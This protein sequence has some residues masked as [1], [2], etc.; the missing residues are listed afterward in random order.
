MKSRPVITLDNLTIPGSGGKPI[1]FDI[2]YKAT[3]K[4]KPIVIFC[5]GFKG[6]KDWGA[7][8][9]MAELF[10]AQNV[11]FIK[12]NFS[13][14]G[15]APG[16]QQDFADLE[17]FGKNTFTKELDDLGRIIDYAVNSDNVTLEEKDPEQ[18][19]LIGH[20][21]GGAIAILKAAEDPR[22][23]K[24]AAWA[25]LNDLGKGWH[26]ERLENWQRE[27]VIFVNNARTLQQMPLYY[28]LYEDYIR[29]GQRLNVENAIK[30]LSVPFTV[31]HGT[32]DEA[33]SFEQALEMKSWNVNIKLHL[34]PGVTHTFG[35]SHPWKG[36]HLPQDFEK[37][38]E[39]TKDF[40]L[41]KK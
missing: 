31:I 18:V 35:S 41:K 12:F 36:H 8:P 19:Y 5:H 26:G 14:N 1:L 17:A 33:V 20:S 28:S 2:H 16:F 4:S 21:R 7:F 15:T 22:V 39:L 37:V 38:L 24:L 27:G 10:A 25:A 34:L 32:D 3:G 29:A 6:F 23:K 9:L 11:V 30:K 13:H 40:F